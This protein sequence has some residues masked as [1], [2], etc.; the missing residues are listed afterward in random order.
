MA[1]SAAVGGGREEGHAGDGGAGVGA[2][3][4]GGGAGASTAG[5]AGAS[6]A[7]ANGAAGPGAHEARRARATRDATLARLAAARLE[8]AELLLG[9]VEL[10]LA[11]LERRL[12]LVELPADG[13]RLVLRVHL[14]DPQQVVARAPFELGDLGLKRLVLLVELRVRVGRVL[15]RLAA[16]LEVVFGDA[17][18][19]LDL[20]QAGPRLVPLLLGPSKPRGVGISR[21]RLGESGLELLYF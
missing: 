9:A 6:A 20:C 19:L 5:T 15:V 2:A 21:V 16:V 17:E 4:G 8:E 14:V 12:E 1:P 3:D 7:A 13:G 11:V 18:L 10:A